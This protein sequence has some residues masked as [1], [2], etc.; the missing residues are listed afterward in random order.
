VDAAAAWSFSWQWW[1][2]EAENSFVTHYELPVNF[3]E[4]GIESV[5]PFEVV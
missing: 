4:R 3:E 1:L 2:L 5:E